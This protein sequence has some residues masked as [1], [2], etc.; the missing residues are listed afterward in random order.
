MAKGPTSQD[1]ADLLVKARE[2]ISNELEESK[3]DDE[4]VVVRE[5]TAS[6]PLPLTQS[7]EAAFENM[8]ELKAQ[9][10]GQLEEGQDKLS[11]RTNDE[12]KEEDTDGRRN[13]RMSPV[14]G[15]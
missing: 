14:R 13:S 7:Q 10:E 9:L 2:I 4:G 8:T 15:K 3:E 5:T 1:V 11:D 12:K 6:R